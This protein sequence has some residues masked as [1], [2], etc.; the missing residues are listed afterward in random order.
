MKVYVLGY[1]QKRDDEVQPPKRPFDPIEDVDVQFC[2]EPV[3]MI[4]HRGLA[5][6]ELRI[7]QDIR[8]RVGLHYCELSLEEFPDGRFGIVCASHPALGD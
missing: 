8:V 7:L 4:P 2:K 3:W 5:E 6:S 1:H